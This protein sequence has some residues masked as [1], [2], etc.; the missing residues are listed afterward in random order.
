MGICNWELFELRV[1]M[2]LRGEKIA[3]SGNFLGVPSW[4]FFNVQVDLK[5]LGIAGFQSAGAN[6][7]N[8]KTVFNDLIK[9][10]KIP[11]GYPLNAAGANRLNF[12]N[13][14]SADRNSL[15]VK[16]AKLYV[17][18]RDLDDYTSSVIGVGI[19]LENVRVSNTKADAIGYF[20]ELSGASANPV[21]F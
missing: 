21:N 18:E 15:P 3:K 2:Y 20:A 16:A 13:L 7:C 17:H 5:S 4:E 12:D 19:L 8:F 14:R 10:K 11:F 6:N 1:A 9:R